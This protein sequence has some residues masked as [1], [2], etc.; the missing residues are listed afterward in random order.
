VNPVRRTPIGACMRRTPC[1]NQ[2]TCTDRPDGNY[3]C[4][5]AFGWQGRHCNESKS[6]KIPL[7]EF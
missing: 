2:A 1:K 6:L 5:C 4:L 3:K 7:A